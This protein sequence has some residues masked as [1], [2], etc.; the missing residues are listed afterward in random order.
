[1]SEDPIGLLLGR[2]YSLALSKSNGK[3]NNYVI[4]GHKFEDET[5]QEIYHLASELGLETNPPRMILRMPTVSGNEHQFDASFVK[6]DIIFVIEC[7]N[8]RVAAKD[9][10]YYFNAKIMDYVQASRRENRNLD[11]RGI[12]LSTIPLADSAWRYAIAYGIR[13]VDPISPPLEHM[14]E[15]ACGDEVLVLALRDLL[16]KVAALGS[17]EY[18]LRPAS[19]SQLLEHYRFLCARWRDLSER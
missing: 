14:I 13:V 5:S 16:D 6:S 8:T 10:V 3:R 11:M 17:D 12:F 18:W 4:E 9:Y 19:P 2:L 1:M 15:T 7:K